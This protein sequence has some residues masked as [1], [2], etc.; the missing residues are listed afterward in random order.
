MLTTG[1]FGPPCA[2][3]GPDGPM[4]STSS[5]QRPSS[6]GIALLALA[7]PTARRAAE[8]YPGDPGSDPTSGPGEFHLGSSQNPCGTAEAWLYRRRAESGS[9]SCKITGK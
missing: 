6:D 7:V 9:P 3:S 5:N 1:C 2:A 8:N 4:S